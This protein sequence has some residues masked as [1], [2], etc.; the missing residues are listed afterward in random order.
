MSDF[1]G[2]RRRC[3]DVS[4]RA[5]DTTS[6][7]PILSSIF[8]ILS[9]YLCSSLFF[10]LCME[11]SVFFVP[12]YLSKTFRHVIKMFFVDLQNFRERVTDQSS[13]GVNLFVNETSL[14]FNSCSYPLCIPRFFFTQESN[15]W[16]NEKLRHYSFFCYVFLQGLIDVRIPG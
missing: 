4:C 14:R 8:L 9:I 11:V 16:F 7:T 1:C 13:D 12:V 2:C 15:V 5:V 6:T 10:L 3:R